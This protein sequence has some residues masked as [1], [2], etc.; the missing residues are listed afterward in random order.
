M[1]WGEALPRSSVVHTVVGLLRT[2]FEVFLKGLQQE[3]IGKR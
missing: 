1:G 2:L 3:M